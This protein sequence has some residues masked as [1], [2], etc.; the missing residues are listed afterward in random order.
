MRTSEEIYHRVRWDARFDPARFVIGVLQRGAAPGRVP[1]PAFVPGG[2]IPWHRVLFFEADGEVVW[3]RTSGVDRMDD[4]DAGRV[5]EARRLRAPFFAARTP[6]VW[7]GADWVPARTPKGAVPAGR[8]RALTWN[9]LWDRYDADRIDTALRRPLLLAALREADADVI[10]LQEVEPRLLTMVLGEAWVR[11]A[12]TLGADPGARDVDECGLLLLSR[13]PVREAG[14]HE[15]GSHKAVSALVVETGAGPVTVAA[16]HLSSDHSDDGAGRR[17][18][19]LASIAEG[20]ASLDGDVVL[21]G[22][23]NDGTD[24]PAA[25][26]GMRDAWSEAHGRGD[27]TPTFDPGVNPLAAVSSLTGRASRLDRVLLRA[28]ALRVRE[29]ALHGDTPTAEGLY[30]SDHYGVRADLDPGGEESAEVLDVRATARTALAWIPPREFWPPLQE[31]RADHDPQIRRW[32]PHVNLLFGFV[33]EHAFERAVPLVAAAAAA[34]APF[35][36]RLAGVQWFGHRDD[37]TVWLDPAAGGE[38]PWAALREALARRF[39]GCRGH[40][41]GFTPHLSLGRTTDPHALAAECTARLAPMPVHVGELALVSRRGAEPM[42]VRATVS[43]GT[44]EVRW[45]PEEADAADAAGGTRRSPAAASATERTDAG[46]TAP[47]AG[48]AGSADDTPRAARVAERVA[49]ALDDGVVHVVGS[50]R[51]GC[52]LPGADLDLVAALPGDARLEDV[53]ARLVAA[54]PGAADVR[55][56][57]GARVPGLRTDVGG[58]TVDLVVVPTGAADPA[59]A[60]E[61][62]TELGAAAAIA[63]SAVSDA[64]AVLALAGDRRE[65]F[66]RL[67]REVKAWAKARGLDSAP[68]GGLPGLAWSLL[69]ARTVRE[70]GDLPPAELLRHFFATWAAWDWREPVV[71]PGAG[72]PDLPAGAPSAGAPDLP[73]VITTPSEPVRPCS[74]QVTP[75]MRDLLTQELFRAWEVLEKGPAG[76]L[77][78]PPLHRRHA[79]WAVVT[80]PPG[81]AEG[82]VRGRMRALLTELS[83]VSPEVH[84]W[85][86]PFGWDPVRLAIGLGATPPDRDVLERI[87]DRWLRGL[88]GV[89]LTRAEGGD[90]PTLR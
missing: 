35:E 3:D 43:L 73:V 61:R 66:T 23:F 22:D 49:N 1:L 33:P 39:P 77:S 47:S 88:T 69:A 45:A 65:T 7:D 19:E 17:D 82:R 28:K 13:L 11:E 8:L 86:R 79:A 41:E 70:A 25:A 34:S 50:R 52:A 40:R 81:P 48:P 16:T 14:H 37:A 32:P 59:T 53:R 85:P 27:T 78:T 63:L 89:T 54:L 20:L 58:L 30:I 60:V 44:G 46:G 15:L 51:M 57:V 87:A 74:D 2:D 75:G 4:T 71:A 12:Y 5:R 9:T 42:R 84:A 56:V 55:E 90:V 62:R 83:E 6:H 10:A 38:E 29:A 80:V 24:A 64:E 76:L 18:T 67:A 26:L 21:M 68:F 72:A 31:I 36:A